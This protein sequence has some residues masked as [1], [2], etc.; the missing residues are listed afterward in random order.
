MHTSFNNEDGEESK[1]FARFIKDMASN[2]KFQKIY[3]TYNSET[4]GILD[5]IYDKFILIYSD[6]NSY[7]KNK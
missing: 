4:Q 5:P 6:L 2:L 3:Y 1:N 7:H